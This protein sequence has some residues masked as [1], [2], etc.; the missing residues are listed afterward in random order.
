MSWRDKPLAVASAS[1]ALTLGLA[2]AIVFTA[3]IPTWLQMKENEIA[4]L[5][6]QLQSPETEPTSAKR[7]EELQ[8]RL[9]AEHL[10]KTVAEKHAA[11]ES[12]LRQQMEAEDR[13]KDDLSGT[14][15]QKDLQKRI[16]DLEQQLEAERAAKETAESRILAETK[17]RQE[18]EQRTRNFDDT[19]STANREQSVTANSFDL[20]TITATA[21][22]ARLD[23]DH[24]EISF[25][26]TNKTARPLWLIPATARSQGGIQASDDVKNSY[27]LVSTGGFRRGALALR[28]DFREQNEFLEL[29]PGVPSPAT[30]KFNRKRGGISGA[31]QI[32]F[33]ATLTVVEDMQ[34]LKSSNKTV[35]AMLNLK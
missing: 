11:D 9:E 12:A 21:D 34:T 19:S 14:A 33:F 27:E 8:K 31:T 23:R 5:K 4:N 13:K 17:L 29:Q 28:G 10:A 1:V 7:I 3:V 24:L 35:T 20:G 25:T 15:R 22:W 32:R 6:R 2:A 18:A 26:F 16:K 30:F